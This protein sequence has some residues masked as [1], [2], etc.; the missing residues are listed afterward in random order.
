MNKQAI[1][2]MTSA[3]IPRREVTDPKTVRVRMGEAS[4]LQLIDVDHVGSAP[5]WFIPY[6][7]LALNFNKHGQ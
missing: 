1:A 7:R 2:L 5:I 6:P 3:R 4:I